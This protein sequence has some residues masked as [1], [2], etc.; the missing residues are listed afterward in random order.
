MS[1]R[2]QETDDSTLVVNEVSDRVIFNI[3]IY[4][5]NLM[6]YCLAETIQD[7]PTLA[8]IYYNIRG[9]LHIRGYS[10]DIGHGSKYRN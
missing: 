9:Q 4:L 7:T 10:M 5:H 1:S 2:E 8:I 6:S 3:C